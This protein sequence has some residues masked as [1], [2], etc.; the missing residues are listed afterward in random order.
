MAF[1]V[2]QRLV[3]FKLKLNRAGFAL[4]DFFLAADAVGDF[5]IDGLVTKLDNGPDPIVHANWR[6]LSERGHRVFLTP[7]AKTS[8]D[9][10]RAKAKDTI[11]RFP[12]NTT[13]PYAGDKRKP[14]ANMSFGQH[15]ELGLKLKALIYDGAISWAAS[16][17]LNSVRSELENWLFVEWPELDNEHNLLAVYYGSHDDDNPY[18]R[19]VQ[20]SGEACVIVNQMHDTLRNFYPNCGSLRKICG[21]LKLAIKYTAKTDKLAA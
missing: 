9:A 10:R 16:R 7:A 5:D 6:G 14:K 19:K 12:S 11:V 2:V 18:S 1:S 8:R 17:R 21:K 4:K 15:Q 20:T 3:A 13:V